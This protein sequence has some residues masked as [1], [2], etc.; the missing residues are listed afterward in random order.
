MGK[1]QI[2]KKLLVIDDEVSITQM[3]KDTL[4]LKGYDVDI[5]LSGEEALGKIRK[6]KP[7]AI[8]LD[9]VM[10]G[11]SGLQILRILKKAPET[12]HIPIIVMS[13]YDNLAHEGMTLG[14]SYALVKPINIHKLCDIIEKTFNALI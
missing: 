11:L 2:K 8:T 7:D 12:Y 9:I 14:A 6:V 4:E 10:P 3:L 5:A 1:I 13:V